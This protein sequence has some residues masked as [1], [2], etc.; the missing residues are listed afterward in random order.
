MNLK[1]DGWE[2]PHPNV[3]VRSNHNFLIVSNNI[4]V[5]STIVKPSKMMIMEVL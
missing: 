2:T 3:A 5:S 4:K 1:F